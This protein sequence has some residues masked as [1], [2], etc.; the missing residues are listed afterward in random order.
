M[1][2]MKVTE[3]DR[4]QARKSAELFAA[5]REFS[6]ADFPPQAVKVL[7]TTL[8]LLAEGKEVTVAAAE[9]D[10]FSTQKAAEYLKVSRPFFINLVE[11]GKI[12]FHKVGTHR[13]VSFS[14][15]QAYKNRI[16]AERLESLAKLTEQAQ[17]LNMGY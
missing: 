9:P 7:K 12:P 6:L 17:E 10:D 8:K 16:D 13:R 1:K 14:D 3:K 11:T 2:V 15:L 4:L 5:N